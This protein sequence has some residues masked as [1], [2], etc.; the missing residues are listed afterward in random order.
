M[1]NYPTEHSKVFILTIII[2]T[3]CTPQHGT[4]RLR[5]SNHCNGLSFHV[6]EPT[7]LDRRLLPQF[8]AGPRDV[9]T[10]YCEPIYILI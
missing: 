9:R 3:L 7:T 4:L 2:H 8:H 10:F 5:Q 1:H 6:S